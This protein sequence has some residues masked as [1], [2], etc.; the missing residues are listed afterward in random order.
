MRKL[1]ICTSM[2][3]ALG[4]AGCGGGETIDDIQAETPI[5]Q[6]SSRIVFNPTAGEISPPTDALVLPGDDGFFDYTLNI[7]VD[8]PTNFGDPLNALNVL[9]GWSTT[10]PWTLDVDTPPGV[11]LD[12]S[13]LSAGVMLYEATLGLDRRDP[14]CAVSEIPSTGCKLGDQLMFGVDFVVQLADE[15]T[16]QVI[17]LRPLK[18]GQG[19]MLLIT[20]ALK[21]STGAGVKGSTSWDL[22]AQ[23]ISTNPLSTQDQLLL[24]TVVNSYINPFLSAGFSRDEISYVSAFTTQSTAT[25]LG[26]AKQVLV[27]EFAAR[28]AAGDPGAAQSLPVIVAQDA[29]GPQN[30]MEA[31]NLVSDEAVAGAVQLG[32]A[33]L[34]AEAAALVPL[35]QST[36][37]SALKT[38]D[39][40][41]GTAAGSLA[42]VWGA[43]NDFAVGVANGIL[44]Q[45]G[46]F[47]AAQRFE[48]SVSLPY[49]LAIPRAENPLAPVNE[50]WEAACDNGVVLAQ[51]PPEAIA[52]ATPGP[53]NALCQQVGLA[54]LRV[55]GTK[56][57]PARNV[58]KFSPIPQPKGG[59]D[60]DEILDVQITVP[61]E[62]V[63][64]ALG[65]PIT[66]PEAG[67]PVAILMHGI[68]RQKEDML[69][70][71]GAL[72][73][74]G[75][76]TI[77]IDHPIHGSRGFDIDPTSPGD[78]L[79]ATTVSATH[80]M[81]LGSLP[82]ARDN[83]RQSVV[84]LLGLRLGL[85]AVVDS[86]MAQVVDLDASN[87]TFFGVSLGAIAGGNFAA[88]ANTTM[89]GELAAL[90]GMFAV[91]AAAL[92]SPG[93]GIPG[94]LLESR[95][96]GPLIKAL[97]ISQSVPEFGEFLVAT[98]GAQ[99]SYTEA[100]LSGAVEPFIAALSS[101]QQAEIAA[102]FASFNFA[103]QT[104]IDSA[105]PINYG[106]LQTSN[107]PTLMLTVVGD[108][109]DMNPSDAVI[110]ISTALPLAGQLP[111]AG[112][113][114]LTE[115]TTTQ[116]GNPANGLVKFNAGAHGSSLSPA[117]NAAVTAEM[118]RLIATYL[119]TQG[120]T[121]Q[122]TDTSVIAN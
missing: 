120:T 13:T 74:A 40:L 25:V 44:Q 64:T 59:N 87:V 102:T 33:S 85:N 4:L 110:P 105:D 86:S 121:I 104:V 49:Y 43:A 111:L 17:P 45:A 113:K 41:L 72:S 98:Y 94:F 84:D 80:F 65:F 83:L 42:G 14:D 119:A 28:F 18:P 75:I 90:D 92:E 57:D 73:L 66:K 34:P 27:A 93:G 78:E 58:T 62:A 67:W 20:N 36:D 21:D 10:H 116:Q 11:S 38:C 16:I 6:P 88:I 7:P 106:Q 9:D 76:A 32:I 50:F 39:G 101:A 60:G 81:N 97:L 29:Q 2:A 47:C 12:A 68:T 82:T 24:Q 96:F 89:G 5:V 63:A 30:A 61:N 118:Q 56:L 108:G 23:D 69:A 114:G 35:L 77:A 46:P 15:N 52:A 53:N 48:A 1:F 26:A 91:K 107:T 51:A 70:L 122:V 31:L 95:S 37:F 55:G 117:A 79:N 19:H 103:A 115:V 109:T 3:V 100:Q 22:V 54:D 99:E 71:S 112:V 8:D